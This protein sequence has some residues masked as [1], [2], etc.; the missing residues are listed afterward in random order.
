M[1]YK[2]QITNESSFE[3]ASKVGW[4]SNDFPLRSIQQKWFF[5][6]TPITH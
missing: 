4:F 6:N 2:I 5:Y 3:S 1:N